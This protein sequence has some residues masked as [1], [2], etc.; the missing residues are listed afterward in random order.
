MTGIVT[1][2]LVEKQIPYHVRESNPLFTKFLEYYYEFQQESKIPDIIQEIKKYN[3][4]DEVEERFLLEFFE[5]FRK[6]PTAIVADRRLVAKHVY[7][8]YKAKGS[9]EALRLLFRIVYGEEIDVYYPETDVLRASDGRWVQKNIVTANR[10]SGGVKSSSNRIEFDTFQGRFVFQLEKSE[11]QATDVTRFWFEP[12]KS[13]YVAPNQIVR[14]YTDDVLDY[15]GRLVL[16]PSSIEVEDGG[17]NWQVGQLL[18]LPGSIRDTICQVK[19]TGDKG[20]IKRL[21]I[22]QYGYGNDSDLAYTVSPYAYKPESSYV[23]AFTEKISD[24][25]PIYSHNLNIFDINEDVAESITGYQDDQEYVLQGYVLQGYIKRLVL[26]QSFVT[27][28]ASNITNPDITIDQ[29]LASRARLKIRN[30]YTAK[31]A[32]YYADQRGQISAP[33]IRL[34]DNFFYQL[35]SYVITTSRMLSE[36]KNVLSLVHP[37]GVKYFANTVREVTVAASINVTR[38]MSRENVIFADQFYV[39]DDVTLVKTLNFYD[40]VNASTL[41]VNNNYD[42]NNDIAYYDA[43]NDWDE[44]IEYTEVYDLNE[45]DNGTYGRMEPTTGYVDIYSIDMFDDGTYYVVLVSPTYDGRYDAQ[46]YDL[47]EYTITPLTYIDQYTLE[48]DTIKITKN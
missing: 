44:I 9:E 19:R 32:G 3:D 30:D 28:P 33:T 34:Q 1:K 15:T 10:I 37:A 14:V 5:E 2:H 35:F 7:D 16:M 18:V 24:A 39:G 41:D 20:S 29:W 8:L 12:R 27:T 36:Y 23:E 21:D 38:V 42:A 26:S 46:E 45:Y 48:D 40:R 4:I 17:E 43:G 25:P 6:L 31:E 11:V 22:I 47:S 13:Y